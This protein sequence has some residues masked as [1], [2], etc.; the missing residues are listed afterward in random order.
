MRRE[1]DEDEDVETG[2]HCVDSLKSQ[3]TN[4]RPQTTAHKVLS[5]F[6]FSA[7]RVPFVSASVRF[8]WCFLVYLGVLGV[9]GCVVVQPGGN[10]GSA[11]P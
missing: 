11:I 7:F 9:L 4:H 10:F 6:R 3:A 5:V 8:W 2:G 1:E